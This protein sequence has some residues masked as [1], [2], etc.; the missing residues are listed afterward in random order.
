MLDYAG[1]LVYL[2]VFGQHILIVGSQEAA[3]EILNQRSAT[4]SDRKESVMVRLCVLLSLLISS[5][6][7]YQRFTRCGLEWLFPFIPYGQAWRRRR[8]TFHQS[9]DAHV[10]SQYWPIQT[11]RARRL[12]RHLLDSPKG[13]EK[14]V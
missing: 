10:V 7:Y 13:L 5:A 14:H 12:I 6:G 4:T 1:D 2:N 8:R 11:F 3:E 9:L